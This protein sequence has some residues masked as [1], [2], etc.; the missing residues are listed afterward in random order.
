MTTY[1]SDTEMSFPIIIIM[2]IRH[3][4]ADITIIIL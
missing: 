3:P 2:N 4:F 1:V